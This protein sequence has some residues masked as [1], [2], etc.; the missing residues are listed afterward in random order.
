MQDVYNI[1][2][3]IYHNIMKYYVDVLSS[4][5][6]HLRKETTSTNKY[7]KTYGRKYFPNLLKVKKHLKN[8]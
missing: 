8:T 2:I 3:C 7:L 6:N 5:S 4:Q 1:Y